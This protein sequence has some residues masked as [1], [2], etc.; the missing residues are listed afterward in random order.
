MMRLY[1]G[2]A[3]FN[4]RADEERREEK[5]GKKILTERSSLLS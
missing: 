4:N 2:G 1:M 3:H 5:E